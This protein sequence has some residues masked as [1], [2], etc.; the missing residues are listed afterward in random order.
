MT[1]LILFLLALI[2]LVIM[3]N[4]MIRLRNDVRRAHSNIDVLL[5]QRSDELPN[6]VDVVKGYAKHEKK[7]F[8]Q[9]AKARSAL[10]S[11]KSVRDAAKADEHISEGIASVLAVAESYPKLQ[12]NENFL[13][14][15]RRITSL[16][17]EL[18]DRREFYN[19]IVTRYNTRIQSVPDMLIAMLCE[20]DKEQLW[21]SKA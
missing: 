10:L 14:L 1:L 11:A 17:N 13:A 12:A 18:A 21:N 2:L 19:E 15:Q 20:M 16:E 7:T 9:L 5:K 8:E 6:L 4:S 3:F